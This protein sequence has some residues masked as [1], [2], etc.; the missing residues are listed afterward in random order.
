MPAPTGTFSIPKHANGTLRSA[1]NNT[2][3][4]RRFVN[5]AALFGD[6]QLSKRDDFIR[7]IEDNENHLHRSC[8]PGHM[9]ASSI[10]IDAARD[11]TVLLKHRKLERWLQPGGHADGDGNLC[12]LYTSP[13][14]RDKRQSR[15]P[16]SA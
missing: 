16:S 6:D 11:K 7:F 1:P 12:L 2:T 13:S 8:V 4:A 5:D 10:V 9:T 14:P 3:R 15:M